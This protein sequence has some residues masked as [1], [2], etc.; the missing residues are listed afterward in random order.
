MI[1]WALG[2][3]YETLWSLQQGLRARDTDMVRFDS[4]VRV[5]GTIIMGFDNSVGCYDLNSVL[6]TN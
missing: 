3:V 5:K 2:R 1:I 4:S 6:S